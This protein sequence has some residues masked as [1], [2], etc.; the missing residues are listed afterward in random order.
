MKKR[1]AFRTVAAL[2]L[3]LCVLLGAGSVLAD[4]SL[5]EAGSDGGDEN[6]LLERLRVITDFKFRMHEEGIGFGKCPVYSAPS[7][8]A[9][10]GANGR[11]AVD[12]DSKMGEAGY[13]A[14]GWLMVRYETSGGNYR[15]GYIPPRYIRGYKT[16]MPT[17]KYD[18]IPATAAGAIYVS[19]SL[20]TY[21]YSARLDEGEPF[22][23]LGKF[24]YSGSWWLIEFML[25]GQVSRGFISREESAFR[26]GNGE[27]VYTMAN[28]GNPGVSPRGT[29]QIGVVRPH[30][31]ERKLVRQQ[32]DVSSKQIT[33]AY[34]D[35]E[36]PCYDEGPGSGR[37]NWYYIFV[38][39]DSKWGWIASGNAD[40]VRDEP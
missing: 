2:L 10:R 35:K 39:S 1:K 16:T 3:A 19:D 5:I 37:I 38:E 9:F 15:V 12:T 40:L 20:S 33:V 29:A 25:D 26:L 24:T 31:G 36:Y 8:Y 32:P 28:L 34:P 22:H 23:I 18:D 30:E 21:S 14:S 17:P 6:A 11:A 13:D 7:E 27:T 4:A